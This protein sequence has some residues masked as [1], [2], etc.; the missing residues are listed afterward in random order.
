MLDKVLKSDEFQS[1]RHSGFLLSRISRLVGPRGPRSNDS[2]KTDYLKR[3]G[4]KRRQLKGR[5]AIEEV[6]APAIN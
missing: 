3:Q 5:V 2:A 4:Q 1:Q 6:V